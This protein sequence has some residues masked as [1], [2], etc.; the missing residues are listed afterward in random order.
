MKKL[1]YTMIFGLLSIV[2]VS[3]EKEVKLY[4]GEEG[5]YFSVQFGPDHGNERVWAH[6]QVTPVEFIN[7]LGDEHTVQLKVMT[8]GRIKDYDRRFSV[9]V[10][11]D[12]TTADEGV[13]YEAL[14]SQYTIKAGEHFTHIPVKLHRSE[15]ISDEKKSLVLR[16]VPNEHFSIGI[17]EWRRLPSYWESA[18]VPGDFMADYHKLEIS[19]FVSRPSQW[20]GL[21]NNGL[22]A[23]WWGLFTEKKYRLICEHFDLVYEDFT[24]TVTMP[25]ARRD[26]IRE[27]MVRFLQDL[28]DKGTPILEEDGRLMWFSGV[29]WTSRVGVPWGGAN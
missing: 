16:L 2:M 23:G 24:S 28:Y 29:S 25:N 18:V 13:E 27:Y 6:Q 9:E 5:I 26:N 10:V 8:T 22:E 21:A 15:G 3:C 14:A 1:I 7:I 4:D 11:R 17:P 19:D 12:T 20:I